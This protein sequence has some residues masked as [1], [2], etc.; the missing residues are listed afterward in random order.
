M[1]S[2]VQDGGLTLAPFRPLYG[3]VRERGLLADDLYTV[4]EPDTRLENVVPFPGRV[5]FG[6]AI[7]RWHEDIRFDSFP[8]DMKEHESFKEIVAQGYGVVPLIAAHLRRQPSFLFLAL[9]D[10]FGEDPVPEQDYGKLST[11]AAAW[12]QWLQG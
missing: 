4:P 11:V 12:L 6:A 8:A 3:D 10:I 9:E 2:A 1:A 5:H 7:A